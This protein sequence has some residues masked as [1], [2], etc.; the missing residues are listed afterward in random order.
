MK[1][2]KQKQKMDIINGKPL[3]H[4]NES[5]EQIDFTLLKLHQNTLTLT[6][7]RTE[8]HRKH[9]LFSENG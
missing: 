4:Y 7:T 6:K 5:C 1:Q 9:L 8:R 2:P 3:V